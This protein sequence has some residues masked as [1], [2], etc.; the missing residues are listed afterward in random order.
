M[1]SKHNNQTTGRWGEQVA[2]E[3]LVE[4]G[5]KVVGRNVRTA[6]GELDLILEKDGTLVFVEVK[7]RTSY[8]YGY[9]E[10]AVTETKKEH[11]LS[12][13]QEFLLER[14]EVEKDWRVDVIAI[15]GNQMSKRKPRIE[16]FE[17]AFS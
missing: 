6:C 10:E 16:W 8:G 15:N 4:K 12:A 5:Y 9:P 2:E 14:S 11:I 13:A 7:T 3:F 1:P 17:N